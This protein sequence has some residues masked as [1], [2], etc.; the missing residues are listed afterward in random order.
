MNLI[1][2]ITISREFTPEEIDEFY[3]GNPEKMRH[4]EK[5]AMVDLL[6]EKLDEGYNIVLNTTMEN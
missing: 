2:D 6:Q 5:D 4:E 3:D 1:I